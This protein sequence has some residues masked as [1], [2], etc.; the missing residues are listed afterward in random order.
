MNLH[1]SYTYRK[2]V[3][4][5]MAVVCMLFFAI[6][7]ALCRSSAAVSK[8]AAGS[9]G[10]LHQLR[11]P[12]AR[13]GNRKCAGRYAL[14]GRPGLS[15]RPAL[16][17]GAGVFLAEKGDGTIGNTVRFMAEVL[18]RSFIN[19]NAAYALVVLPM[20][21]FPRWRAEGPCDP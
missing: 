2:V 4:R 7:F 15:H 5:G 14:H 3:D 9:R 6:A 20:G 8:G 19:G 21:H 10:L 13:L 17:V 12:S 11:S 18:G 16:G 1:S